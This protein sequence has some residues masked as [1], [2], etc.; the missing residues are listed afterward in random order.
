M[1]QQQLD[2]A[3]PDLESLPGVPDAIQLQEIHFIF[4]TA[5][6]FDLNLEKF[7]L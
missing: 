5:L 1:A 7:V 3:V 6:P 2:P 4:I